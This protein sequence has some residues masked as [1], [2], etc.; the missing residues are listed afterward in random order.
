MLESR[1]IGL[2]LRPNSRRKL[3]GTIWELLASPLI[4]ASEIHKMQGNGAIV[5]DGTKVDQV[6]IKNKVAGASLN[7]EAGAKAVE[8][9][10]VG[11]K[12][13]EIMQ[14]SPNKED[15]A[16]EAMETDG[17]SPSREDGA[18]V[19]VEVIGTSPNKDSKEVGVKVAVA[20]GGI[21]L[22]RVE[23]IAD[24]VTSQLTKDSKE[25]DGASPTTT[26][27][28]INLEMGG[29]LIPS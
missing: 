24:G 8:E 21:S 23:I 25:V 3:P 28:E 1:L 12:V 9:T 15:G 6:P 26:L 20:A 4:R 5:V 7:R 27:G 18:K 14:I 19:A 16:K 13:V 2:E 22:S 17:T 11:V 29:D 10:E